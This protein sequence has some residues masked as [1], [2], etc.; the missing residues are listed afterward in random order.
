MLPLYVDEL[1]LVARGWNPYLDRVP[2]PV[3]LVVL[4]QVLAKTGGLDP[5]NAVLLGTEVGAA[6]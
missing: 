6:A 3:G 4:L 5:N 1:G 2:R